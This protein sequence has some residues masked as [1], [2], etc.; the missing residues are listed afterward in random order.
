M[1]KPFLLKYEIFKWVSYFV[2]ISIRLNFLEL[3]KSR[4]FAMHAYHNLITTSIQCNKLRKSFLCYQTKRQLRNC[5]SCT[6]LFCIGFKINFNV[7]FRCVFCYKKIFS[8]FL[9]FTDASETNNTLTTEGMYNNHSINQSLI[10][11]LTLT[12][13]DC[14]RHIWNY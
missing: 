6:L 8:I 1:T 11:T 12:I 13:N 7:N 10:H 5:I 4:L 2:L 14:I 3:F 9:S